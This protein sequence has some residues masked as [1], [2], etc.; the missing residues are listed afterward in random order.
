MGRPRSSLR[1]SGGNGIRGGHD[2]S[3]CGSIA[4]V[5]NADDQKLLT[6]S[7]DSRANGS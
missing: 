2:L 6:F 3:V 7:Q 4:M 1:I 5:R